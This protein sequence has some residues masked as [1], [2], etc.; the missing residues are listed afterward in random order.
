M[1]GGL[2]SRPDGWGGRA[3]WEKAGFKVMGTSALPFTLS[4][5]DKE[6]TERQRKEKGISH[7]EAY[8]CFHMMCDL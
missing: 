2:E 3:F 1:S 7:E 5:F 6:L 4:E 8:A